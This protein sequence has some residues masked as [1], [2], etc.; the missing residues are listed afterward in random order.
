ML[1]KKEKFTMSDLLSF[2]LNENLKACKWRAFSFRLN[3]Y[4][5]SS[6]FIE[7]F[8][9]FLTSLVQNGNIEEHMGV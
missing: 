3:F 4:E 5:K 6:K 2:T 9:K 1:N 7:I 8:K